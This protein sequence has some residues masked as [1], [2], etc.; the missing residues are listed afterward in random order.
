M[1]KKEYIINGL[2]RDCR[3]S[4]A[5]ALELPP[6]CSNLLSHW[7]FHLLKT[8]SIRKWTGPCCQLMEDTSPGISHP[9]R[10]LSGYL[11]PGQFNTLRPRKNYHHLA[12]QIFKMIYFLKW[13]LVQIILKFLPKVLLVIK[14]YLVLVMAWHWL[15]DITWTSVDCW[16]R[17]MMQHSITGPQ[18][19]KDAF[20]SV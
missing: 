11:G 17:S 8:W 3:D 9:I 18:W 15:G 19:V 1:E 2:M 7:Y 13:K 6:S 5:D 12:E 20:L 14:S 16:S 4:I 10:A